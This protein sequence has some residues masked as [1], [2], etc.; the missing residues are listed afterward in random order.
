MRIDPLLRDLHH[1]RIP[2][3]I[4]PQRLRLLP[5]P[6]RENHDHLICHRCQDMRR[7]Q[8]QP[9]LTHNHPAP[10]STS[11]TGNQRHR[12]RPA[13]LRHPHQIPVQPLQILQAPD[14]RCLRRRHHRLRLRSQQD[15]A[16]QPQ[17]KAQRQ[18]LQ[19]GQHSHFHRVSGGRAALRSEGPQ[20]PD[21]APAAPTCVEI[22][23]PG[24]KLPIPAAFFRFH[25]PLP[26]ISPASAPC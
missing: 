10:R 12:R 11:P 4:R 16:H 8:D 24:Q 22:D 6:I 5:R 3:K 2:I 21:Q 13:A 23:A 17:N 20:C 26:S 1:R 9:V 25:L 7:G 18:G 15:R 14:Q 19:R